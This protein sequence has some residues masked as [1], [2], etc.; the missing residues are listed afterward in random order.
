MI[1]PKKK[2]FLIT[3]ILLLSVSYTCFFSIPVSATY[4]GARPGSISGY[5]SANCAGFAFG[6]NEQI[7]FSLYNTTNIS[8]WNSCSSVSALISVLRYHI[9]SV[10]SAMNTMP[11]YSNILTKKTNHNYTPASN[12]YKVAFKIGY[13]DEKPPYNVINIMADGSGDFLDVHFRYEGSDGCW[14]EKLNYSAKRKAPFES[15]NK[16][17]INPFNLTWYRTTANSSSSI[18]RYQGYHYQRNNWS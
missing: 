12:A 10:I 2:V 15:N 6:Y 13:E 8:T 9:N 1:M 16:D 14:Y 3:V 4:Y 18:Y 11:K 17:D 7:S 5:Y